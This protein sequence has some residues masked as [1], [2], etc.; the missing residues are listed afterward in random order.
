MSTQRVRVG[1]KDLMADVQTGSNN[2]LNVEWFFCEALAKDSG[3]FRSV[4]LQFLGSLVCIFCLIYIKREKRRKLV[5]RLYVQ[6]F[7]DT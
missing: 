5:A 3:F 7:V 1:T 2:C 6:K 4:A